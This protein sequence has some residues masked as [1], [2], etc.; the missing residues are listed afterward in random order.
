M[1]FNFKVNNQ[2]IDSFG[3]K[4]LTTMKTELSYENMA[5]NM[6]QSIDW[7]FGVSVNSSHKQ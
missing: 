7:R 6:V 3:E 1:N 2:L 4:M 5:Q